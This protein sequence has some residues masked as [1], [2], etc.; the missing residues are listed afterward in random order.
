MREAG[1]AAASRRA[2]DQEKCQR[3]ARSPAYLIL[4]A[5]T[6]C[7][8]PLACGA[9]GRRCPT[10]CFAPTPFSFSVGLRR[11]W[12]PRPTRFAPTP[13]AVDHLPAPTPTHPH[14]HIPPHPHTHTPTYPHTPPHPHTHIP[15]YPHTHTLSLPHPHT[16]T[17]THP[18]T[19]F[20][21]L[22]LPPSPPKNRVKKI[23]S[24]PTCKYCA[25]GCNLCASKKSWVLPRWVES[26]KSSEKALTSWTGWEYPHHDILKQ[27]SL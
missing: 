5:D 23:F 25:C 2:A 8:L 10:R 16:H 3:K 24:F 22:S 21:S 26:K 11:V 20:P 12:R 19:L 9:A 17:P 4:R 6:V 18:H 13:I 27:V 1:R 14:T 7:F 15:T